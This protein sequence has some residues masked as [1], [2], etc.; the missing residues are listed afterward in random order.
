MSKSNGGSQL[1]GRKLSSFAL[2]QMLAGFH[3]GNAETGSGKTS[4]GNLEPLK[5][6]LVQIFLLQDD[7][8]GHMTVEVS[9]GLIIL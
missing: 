5:L 3:G 6:F 4:A 7:G 2:H 9:S 8:L 1:E